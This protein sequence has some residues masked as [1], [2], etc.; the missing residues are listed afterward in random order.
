MSDTSIVFN[1]ILLTDE[2]ILA[3]DTN[4]NKWYYDFDEEQ[5]VEGTGLISSDEIPIED[6]CIEKKY[7]NPLDKSI[8]VGTD[9][10]VDGN[11]I[12]YGKVTVHG[13]VKGS[14]KSFN[15]KVLVASTGRVDGNVEAPDIVLRDGGEILG[16]E[17]ITDIS[18]G[19]DDLKQS[20][21]IDGVI[22]V[23]SLMFFIFF[24]GFLLLA[25]IPK[26][27]EVFNQCFYEN[28]LKTT[29]IGL[30]SFFLMPLVFA[31]VIITIVGIAL[32]PLIP[33]IYT[34]AMIMGIVAFSNKL[35]NKVSSMFM[36]KSG[37]IFFTTFVGLTLI[38]SGWILT[39]ILLGME[40][41]VSTGFGIFALVLMIIISGYPI[42]SGLGSAVLTRFGFKPYKKLQDRQPSSK[43]SAPAPPP[44]PKLKNGF[45]NDSSSLVPPKI[46]PLSK[47]DNNS[48]NN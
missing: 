24:V 10:Y 35:G 33:L 20:F 9:Q 6:R 15:G 48:D 25:L 8:T 32:T 46:D 16:E 34:I 41:G 19:L 40:S 36:K 7:V 44:M 12:V 43:P 39:A 3:V 31:L 17:I 23:I 29:M 18:I 38:S 5:F 1:K 37:N 22:I 45:D 4:G 11:I 30:A 21:D 14:V 13:W 42:C 47:R 2:G 27:I 26:K 28:R